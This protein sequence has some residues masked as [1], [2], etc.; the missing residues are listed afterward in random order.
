MK[1]LLPS[2]AGCPETMSEFEGVGVCGPK[3]PGARIG[4]TSGRV[5]GSGGGA[6]EPTQNGEADDHELALGGESKKKKDPQSGGGPCPAHL[7]M[8]CKADR[9][10]AAI[11]RKKTGCGCFTQA[12]VEQTSSS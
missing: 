2:R 10:K 1:V 9:G 4:R 8:G 7:P 11:I 6:G 5:K 3:R 12:N